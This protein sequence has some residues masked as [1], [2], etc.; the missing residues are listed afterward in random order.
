MTLTG[1]MLT[2]NQAIG[3][4]GVILA[5]GS[6]VILSGNDF[7][8]NTG[9]GNGGAI[10]SKGC[11]IVMTDHNTFHSNLLIPPDSSSSG[12]A[13]GIK[14]GNITVTGSLWFSSNRAGVGGAISLIDT[15]AK[16]ALNTMW[17]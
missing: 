10:Y 1:N 11:A 14:N 12:G 4:G 16:F 7:S 17:H 5:Y 15:V 2:R 6:T 3:S 8:H 9:R 13:I